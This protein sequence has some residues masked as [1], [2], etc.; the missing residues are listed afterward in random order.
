V[1]ELAC[2]FRCACAPK[3]FYLPAKQWC[4]CINSLSSIRFSKRSTT[5]TAP[6]AMQSTT[7]MK[8]FFILV[9]YKLTYTILCLFLLLS[10]NA[11]PS[12]TNLNARLNTAEFRSAGLKMELISEIQA[13]ILFSE[14]TAFAENG[15][16]QWLNT[17][18]E[19]R[20]SVDVLSP[21]KTIG[22]FTVE[23]KKFQQYYRG[24][25]VEHG[26][27]KASVMDGQVKS[28]QFEFYSI[29]DNFKM[30][31]AI[32]EADALQRA[33]S[34]LGGKK[35]AWTGYVGNDPDYL[36]PRGELV[37]ISTYDKPDEVCLAYRFTVLSLIP[38]NKTRVY[39]N[40]WNGNIVLNDPIIKHADK[41]NSPRDSEKIK[42]IPKS[43]DGSDRQAT[44]T[45]FKVASNVPG[46]A[47]TRYV[48][49]QNITTDNGSTVP[50]KPYRLRE[51]RNGHNI[52]TLNY[53]GNPFNTNLNFESQAIDFVD[54]DNNW[55]AAE[56]DNINYDNGATDVQH[57]MEIVSDYWKTVHNRNSWDNNYG[58][59]RSF[60]HVAEAYFNSAGVM[61][62]TNYF[63]NAFWDGRSMHFGDGSPDPTVE[64]ARTALDVS[65]HELGHGVTDMNNAL[66][67]QW[68][69]GALNEGFSD[70]WAACISNYGQIH[71]NLPGEIT[72]RH[73]EKYA[74]QDQPEKG[75][76]DFSNPLIFH[77]PSTYNSLY[78]KD[79]SY[80]TCRDFNNTDNCGVHT[81]SGVLNKWFYLITQGESSINTAF[82]PYTV[83]GLGFG[84]SQKIA[85]LTSLNLT[86]NA[87]YATARAVSINAAITLY[88]EGSAA[89]KSVRDA[90]VAV[91]VGTN[92]HNMSNSPAFTTNNFT[93]VAIDKNGDVW[94]G[95]NSN[96][97]YRYTNSA[98]EKRSEIPNVR[99][100]D[101]KTDKAGNIWVAQSGT[102]ASG[103]QALSGGVNYFRAP[104]GATDH[105]FYTIGAQT[106]VPSRNARCIFVDTSRKTDG[107][108]PTVWVATLAYI[109]SGNSTSGMLGQGLYNSS[110]NFKKVSGGLNIASNTAGV[111]TV[112]GNKNEIWTFAQANNGVN[113]LLL[114]NAATNAFITYFDHNTDPII[115]SG[116]VARSI[117]GDK[118]KRIWIA[119]ANNGV[120]VLDENQNWHHV[121]FSHAFPAGTQAS[122][123][124]ICGSPWGD[125]Y[126]GTNNG[127]VYFDRGNGMPD[128]I[129]NPANYRLFNKNNGLPSNMVNAL[130]Y[131]TSRFKLIV[132]SDSGIVFYEPL[133]LRPYCKNFQSNDEVLTSTLGSGNWS[134]PMIW[135]DNKIPDSTTVVSITDSIT[136]D[137]NARA[138]Q[139]TVSDSGYLKVRTGFN[140]KLFPE[141]PP[142]YFDSHEHADMR[143]RDWLNARSQ[144]TNSRKNMRRNR[145]R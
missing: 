59:V 44:T 99:I 66:V 102:Q 58:E 114:Y 8:S 25:K 13:G 103:S 130:A 54:N 29:P 74:R 121:N 2:N 75:L 36:Q 43:K 128:K 95:T 6:A 115:P 91:G 118:K 80:R 138:R 143:R 18:L 14:R 76:R 5:Y 108:N 51:T 32:S 87:S 122:F 145:S 4:N 93:S 94:A 49:Q 56:Y 144:Q 107:T 105:S 127:I 50:G 52:V 84:I 81:N 126:I 131:D 100:N 116:F 55:T 30:Q 16:Q 3:I 88:G 140:L 35:Y 64:N 120:L 47:A 48:G 67:Y 82:T 62:G 117:Y 141:R 57:S 41:I 65:S 63:A 71:H 7:A 45:T 111:S 86:P 112:G 61:L 19:L 26:I 109:T 123:N 110:P 68:E 33:M 134:N 132:A 39:V 89:V 37:I 53:Q 73:G 1:R 101:I 72:W 28:L 69:S 60:V 12:L 20:Q 31:V 96:G 38:Y 104:F 113:Q 15:L 23:V 125:V 90:W 11:Q 34:H 119:L 133:C 27:V 21:G 85:Y 137:I 9:F 136:V 83:T 124:A 98:W 135:S 17:N 92:V 77:H 40:A 106:N 22:S 139:V 70:I 10:A 46:T 24:L 129:D 97:I 78:W 42:V 79:A 142:I